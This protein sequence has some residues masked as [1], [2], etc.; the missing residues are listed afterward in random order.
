MRRDP[1]LLAGLNIWNGQVTCLPVARQ[2]GYEPLPPE[3]ALA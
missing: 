2:H 1:H 3:A